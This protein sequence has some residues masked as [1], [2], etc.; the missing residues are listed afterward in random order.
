MNLVVLNIN[1]I[2]N[3]ETSCIHFWI[4]SHNN[5]RRVIYHTVVGK[6]S[7]LKMICHQKE[8]LSELTVGP[9]SNCTTRC[10]LNCW[11]HWFPYLPPKD[12]NR[13]PILQKGSNKIPRG[14]CSA[15]FCDILVEPDVFNHFRGFIFCNV[16]R[17]QF[18]RNMKKTRT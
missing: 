13:S 16:K 7:I 4:F 14:T 1:N 17:L 11:C 9:C 5:W 15:N 3:Y 12:S 6:V 10:H 18:Y 2:I 8:D